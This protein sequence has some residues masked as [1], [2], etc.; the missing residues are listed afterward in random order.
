MADPNGDVGN[1]ASLWLCACGGQN[2]MTTRRC[3][4]CGQSLA[5][6]AEFMALS[7]Y[8]GRTA[9]MIAHAI[10]TAC[11]KPVVIMAANAQHQEFLQLQVALRK[12]PVASVYPIAVLIWNPSEGRHAPQRHGIQTLF[13]HHTLEPML[14]W[15]TREAH[16][17]DSPDE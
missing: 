3:E 5:A 14:T 7:H 10:R 2:T 6:N 17:F 4:K 12:R 11:E 1:A 16:R 9:R 8:T 13:D 15:M